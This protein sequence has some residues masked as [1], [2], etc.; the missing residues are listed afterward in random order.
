MTRRSFSLSYTHTHTHTHT[1]ESTFDGT[2]AE[3]KKKRLQHKMAEGTK[4][5]ENTMENQCKFELREKA[6]TDRFKIGF[7]RVLGSIWEGFGTV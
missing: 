5:L 6:C 1:G 3:P 2:S 7:G 4:T